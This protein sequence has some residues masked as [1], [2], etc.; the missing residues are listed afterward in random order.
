MLRFKAGDA[1]AFEV[2][3]R[4]HRTPVFSFLLRLTGDRSRA[5][6]LCQET[7]LRVV[8]ASRGWE[9]RARFTTWLFGIARNV[10]SAESRRM[11]FRRAEPL[12]PAGP[13]E[14][15]RAEAAAEDPPP[16]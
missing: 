13:G 1:G 15:R 12:D 6:D 5:E 8:K 14:Q 7:F 3:V 4:R 11:A 9:E 16:D 2:L 10:A